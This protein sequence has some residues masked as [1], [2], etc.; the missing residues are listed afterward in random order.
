MTIRKE[1]LRFLQKNGVETRFVSVV[2]ERVYIN[3]LKL[4]GFHAK[5]KNFF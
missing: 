3:N 2:G 4:S 5:R 1:V